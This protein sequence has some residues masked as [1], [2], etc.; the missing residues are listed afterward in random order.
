MNDLHQTSPDL[1]SPHSLNSCARCWLKEQ[2]HQRL[3]RHHRDAATRNNH[4]A[5]W[6]INM[7]DIPLNLYVC[8]W[9]PLS[10]WTHMNRFDIYLAFLIKLSWAFS[11]LHLHHC[12]TLRKYSYIMLLDCTSIRKNLE[13]LNTFPVASSE[14][15]WDASGQKYWADV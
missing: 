7:V 12:V 8:L 13:Y 9:W 15:E 1:H 5:I 6:S 2:R 14:G 10:G 11:C 4:L 3:C